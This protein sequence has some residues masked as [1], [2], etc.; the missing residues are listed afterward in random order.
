MTETKTDDM[1]SQEED[2]GIPEADDLVRSMGLVFNNTFLY[3]SAHGVT[4]KAVEES[5]G[6][7]TRILEQCE[8]IVFN[9]TD[10]G[11]LVNGR[12]I[13]LKNPL[14]HTFLTHLAELEISSFSLTRGMS[15]IKF[16]DLIEVL[17]AKPEELQTL[18]GFAEVVATVGLENVRAS[19][20]V[21][22]RIS[23]DELVTSKEEFVNTAVQKAGGMAGMK[24][25]QEGES[26]GI[27]E[28]KGTEGVNVGG[29]LAFLKGDVS[30]QETSVAK[31]IQDVASDSNKLADLI[32]H[33]A[34]VRQESPDIEGGESFG[35]LVVGCLRR[36]YDGLSKSPSI[37]TQKGKKTLTKSLMLLE[38]DVLDKMREMAGEVTTKDEEAVSDVIEELATELKIDSLAAEYMKKRNAVDT[39]EERLLRFIKTKGADQIGN[40]ALEEKLSE[41]GLTPD[42]WQE[43]L[44]K[45]GTGPC[46]LRKLKKQ[47]KRAATQTPRRS[48]RP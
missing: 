45:S 10:D 18:G 33:A 28:A 11:L 6:F 25:T 7:L 31:D 20:V 22:K 27:S 4:K 16:N 15:E 3:G 40:T 21:Y 13:E 48:R 43:L 24:E 46:C 41:G 34:V 1:S 42:G 36:A 30:G 9:T 19:K 26:K 32:L 12:Q 14:M 39:S 38:K 37:K 44:I 17:N 8:E 5:F 35:N 47:R 23:E 29:I 2:G